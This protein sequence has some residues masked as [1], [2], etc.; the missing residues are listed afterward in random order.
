M[1]LVIQNLISIAQKDVAEINR[2]SIIIALNN[3]YS[4]WDHYPKNKTKS[5]NIND[6]NNNKN[7]SIT[8]AAATITASYINS[9][10][11]HKGMESFIAVTIK[12][13]GN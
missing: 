7:N 1:A 3:S 12:S 4:S 10:K 13:C 6:S 2:I 5:K 11:L 8:T 9:H